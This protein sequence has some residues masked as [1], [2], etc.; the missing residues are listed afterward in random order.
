MAADSNEPLGTLTF[1]RHFLSEEVRTWNTFHKVRGARCMQPVHLFVASSPA[2]AE[3]DSDSIPGIVLHFTTPA[4]FHRFSCL[5][6][7]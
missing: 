4:V 1:L 6:G 2:E 3:A 7:R 5:L